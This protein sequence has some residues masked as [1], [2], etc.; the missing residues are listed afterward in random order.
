MTRQFVRQQS[1]Y[2]GNKKELATIQKRIANNI[3]SLSK[4]LH[5]ITSSIT[6]V[7]ILNEYI[8]GKRKWEDVGRLFE[9]KTKKLS[10]DE[11]SKVVLEAVIKAKNAREKSIYFQLYT[12]RLSRDITLNFKIIRLKLRFPRIKH[13][14]NRYWTAR[15]QPKPG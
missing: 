5:D 12:D 6:P 15:Q 1:Q 11:K 7:E 10:F 3:A 13:F 14:G 4:K 8:A 9:V 2:V